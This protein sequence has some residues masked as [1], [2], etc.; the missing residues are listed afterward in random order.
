MIIV[1]LAGQGRATEL[2]IPTEEITQRAWL[3]Q[4]KWKQEA[5]AGFSQVWEEA[6]S[7][8][9]GGRGGVGRKSLAMNN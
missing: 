6:A 7:W 1:P 8:H 3:W 2:G 4:G 9:M 5:D